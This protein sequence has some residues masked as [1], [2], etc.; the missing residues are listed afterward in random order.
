[1]TT[2]A[3]RVI[4]E[5]FAEE[6]RSSAQPTAKPSV[7]VIN[8]RTDREDGNERQICRVPIDIIRFRKENGRIAS[9]VLD[10]E[11]SVG[12][13]NERDIEAQGIIKSFLEQKD[14]EK[15]AILRKSILHTGQQEPAIITCDGFLI[16]GNRRKMV[17]DALHLE[18]PDDPSFAFMKVVILPGEGDPGGP[19]TLLEI[20][21]LENRYQL[22]S[23]GKSEYYGFDRALSIQ[24]KIDIGL[25]LEDQLRDDPRYAGATKAQLKRAVRECEKQFLEPLACVDRYLQQFHREGAYKTISTGMT[26]REGRWQAFIDYSNTH[27][28]YFSNAKRRMEYGIDETEIG[29]IEVAAFNMIRLRS[30]PDLPKVHVIMRNLPKYCRT[31]EGKKEI[32]KIADEV[33]P[34]LSSEEYTDKNG[35]PLSQAE[36]DA[37]WAAKNQRAIIYHTKK[38]CL[39]HDILR[40]KETPIGLLEAAYKKL[41]HPDMDLSA[42]G[43]EDN[44]K[45]MELARKIQ[46]KADE[47]ET[48]IY[49]QKKNFEK[50]IQKKQ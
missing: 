9:D 31:E 49:H 35:K 48:Q 43:L 37:K 21:K 28:R 19:P 39:N 2:P 13:L 36:I 42:I 20:E 25:S 10:F 41:T 50:L 18:L 12:T 11:R 6:I 4:I 27:T 16:N 45:A 17:M 29:E 22:Q 23:D 30:L 24:R 47:L 3:K 33:E 38:A 40:D 46:S 7:T 14:P 34:V 15:T 1:M 8:F 32:K 5:D 26:D 44:R